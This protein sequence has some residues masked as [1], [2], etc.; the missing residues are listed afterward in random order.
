MTERFSDS[1]A[2]TIDKTPDS[3][4]TK[5]GSGDTNN[6]LTSLNK[7]EAPVSVTLTIDRSVG[8]VAAWIVG[9]MVLAIAGS[10][11]AIFIAIAANGRS[12]SVDQRAEDMRKYSDA[13][14]EELASKFTIVERENRVSQERLNDMK[15]ELAKRGIASSDH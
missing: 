8:K 1:T 9:V 12:E 3:T 4:L 13:R 14:F 10:V 11:T 2:S 6:V 15:V 7:A 5:H